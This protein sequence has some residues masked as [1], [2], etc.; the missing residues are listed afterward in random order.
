MVKRKNNTASAVF[1]FI[2][3]SIDVKI[4]KVNEMDYITVI[5][6]GLA[7]AEAAYQI[8]KKGIK[9]KLSFTLPLDRFLPIFICIRS[10]IF[11]FSP[12]ILTMYN[13]ECKT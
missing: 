11:I 4:K 6:A 13:E 10:P 2:K 3:K 5:G 9:V 7:G 1:F 8:A 12:L